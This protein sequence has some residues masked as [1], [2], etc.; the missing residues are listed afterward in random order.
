MYSIHNTNDYSLINTMVRMAMVG[1]N[2]DT[3]K[4]TTSS[5]YGNE[6]WVEFNDTIKRIKASYTDLFNTI[7]EHDDWSENEKNL[8]KHLCLSSFRSTFVNNC[9]SKQIPKTYVYKTK[10]YKTLHTFTGSY[11]HYTNLS[12]HVRGHP[13]IYYKNAKPNNNMKRNIYKVSNMKLC[14]SQIET[15]GLRQVKKTPWDLSCQE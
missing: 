8:Q 14:L 12:G 1:Q 2:T 13:N 5:L 9:C 11:S 7:D 6:C 4:K 3:N 15:C 10:A